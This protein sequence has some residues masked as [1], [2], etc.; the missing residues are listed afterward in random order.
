MRLLKFGLLLGMCFAAFPGVAQEEECMRGEP[1]PL[2]KAPS[3][4]QHGYGFQKVAKT[5]A[6]ESFMSAGRDVY[7]IH[8]WGCESFVITVRWESQAAACASLR[9]AERAGAKVLRTF[10]KWGADC[11]FDL[12]AAARLLNRSKGDKAP[13]TQRSDIEEGLPVP[14]DGTDFLQTRVSIA[15]HGQGYVEVQLMKGPL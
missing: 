5:E 15:A 10:Q 7:R 12:E 8:H 2:F 13:E 11:P 6:W 4:S 14:G 9:E 1:T 3:T